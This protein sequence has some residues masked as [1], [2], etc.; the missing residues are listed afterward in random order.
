MSHPYPVSARYRTRAS[1]MT[2]L[3]SDN[4]K[5]RVSCE[6]MSRSEVMYDMVFALCCTKSDVPLPICAVDLVEIIHWLEAHRF[7]LPM[8]EDAMRKN[9]WCQWDRPLHPSSQ[10]EHPYRELCAYGVAKRVMKMTPDEMLL[11][12][13]MISDLTPAMREYI[14]QTARPFMQRPAGIELVD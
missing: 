14:A 12:F 10:L 6:T 1:R 8:T 3:S 5:F 9:E 2:L 7:D 13:N 4:M 11:K